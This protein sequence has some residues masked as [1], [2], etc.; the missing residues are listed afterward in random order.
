MTETHRSPERVDLLQL[1]ARDREDGVV[2]GDPDRLFAVAAPGDLDDSLVMI[3]SRE[4]EKAARLAAKAE[5]HDATVETRGHAAAAEQQ[6]QDNLG[7][8]DAANQKLTGLRT[9]SAALDRLLPVSYRQPG[10]SE[11][12]RYA[13]FAFLLA[14]GDV[15]NVVT[16]SRNLGDS[17]L[18]AVCFGLGLGVTGVCIGTV[19]GE[20]RSRR[21]RA[22][23]PLEM[24]EDLPEEFHAYFGTDR[25]QAESDRV[26]VLAI[27]GTVCLAIAM[28]ALRYA[29]FGAVQ[30]FVYGLAAVALVIGSFFNSYVHAQ[31]C[32]V[33][34]HRKRVQTEI[35]GTETRL[36]IL[37]QPAARAAELQE[38]ITA[39]EEAFEAHGDSVAA[40]IRAEALSLLIAEPGLS[41][42]HTK[43]HHSSS[44]SD[45]D[46]ESDGDSSEVPELRPTEVSLNGNA[47]RAS[48]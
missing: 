35:T 17:T 19:G 24:P 40:I 36:Q 42:T 46:G 6:A 3:R 16:Q 45:V 44:A 2:P 32:E 5:A 18:P 30:G 28:F 1:S 27:I 7:E 14:L 43:L 12:H 34:L 41:G 4:R 13:F 21:E 11:T 39:I 26:V 37:L 25:G 31:Q 9:I 10:R 22:K 15:A 48:A 33:S 38:E 8:I 29:L 20:W 47:A 23:R